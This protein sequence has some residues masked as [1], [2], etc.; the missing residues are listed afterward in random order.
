MAKGRKTKKGNRK[1]P[2]RL[3]RRFVR[4]AGSKNTVEYAS[5]SEARTMS[6]PGPAPFTQKHYIA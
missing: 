6:A 3:K 1:G 2:G 5:M 4:R